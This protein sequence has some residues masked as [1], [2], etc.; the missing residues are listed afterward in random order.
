LYDGS[1]RVQCD[2]ATNE[3]YPAYSNSFDYTI[4]SSSPPAVGGG[5]G[6]GGFYVE[7]VDNETLDKLIEAKLRGKALIQWSFPGHERIINFL[8]TSDFVK[9]VYFTVGAGPAEIVSVVFSSDI[10]GYFEYTICNP[11]D[12]KCRQIVPSMA[13]EENRYVLMQ[14]NLSNPDFLADFLDDGK[15]SG[16]VYLMSGDQVISPPYN[17]TIQKSR[18]YDVTHDIAERFGSLTHKAAYYFTL[19]AILCGCLIAGSFVLRIAGIV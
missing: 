13:T 14:G 17:I 11:T 16:S 4:I 12:L 19:V 18:L 9:E 3:G 7:T 10:A 5:G 6:G 15:V 1:I 8:P 2:N